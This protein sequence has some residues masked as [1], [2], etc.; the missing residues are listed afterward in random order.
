MRAATK[1]VHKR[2]VGRMAFIGVERRLKKN[3]ENENLHALHRVRVAA[4]S[5]N[6]KM[7]S[8]CISF[9]LYRP[10][11]FSNSSFLLFAAL[12]F[13]LSVCISANNNA[14][15]SFACVWRDAFE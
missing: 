1:I 10:S 6:D 14:L 3:K 9:L 13:R 11:S 2:K 7:L 5:C 8:R 15:A 4:E 12:C